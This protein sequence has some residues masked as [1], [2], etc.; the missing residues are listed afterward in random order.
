VK[1]ITILLACVLGVIALCVGN[2]PA[3]PLST[4]FTYQGSIDKSG[5][6]GS[7]T[8]TFTFKLFDA[9]NNGAQIG[10]TLSPAVTLL[11]NGQFSVPLDF[12][13]GLFDGN[14]RWLEITVQCPGDPAPVALAPRQ[15]LTAAP[16]ALYA[17]N[18]A[19]GGG[20]GFVLPYVGPVTSAAQDAFRIQNNA[21]TGAFSAIHG[22]SASATSG[23]TGVVFGEATATS[24]L[25]LGVNGLAT[26]SPQGTGVVGKGGATGGYFES[27]APNASSGF[28]GLFGV[29]ANAYGVRGTSTT[30]YGVY[31]SG[32]DGVHGTGTNAGVSGDGTGYGVLASSN[33]GY[34]VYATYGNFFS[35]P[36][37][38]NAGVYG[39][40]ASTN[41]S[42]AGVRGEGTQAS[43]VEGISSS[44]AGVYGHSTSS[45]GVSGASPSYFGVLGV[46]GSESGV[47][48][49]SGSASGVYGQ[50]SSPTG[51]GVFGTNSAG[52][53]IWGQSS[54]NARSG[55]VGVS[56]SA[57]GIGGFFANSAG[58]VALYAN[59]L[60]QVK[61]L[62]ILGADLAESFPVKERAIEPGTV[63]MIDGGETGVLRV[64]DDAYSHRVAGVVSGAN[65]LDA[66]VVLK[67]K[68]FDEPGHVSV[69]MSG[70]VW[71]KCDAG[72]QP[73]RPGD[74]LT[75]SER[76][77]HAMRATD[78]ERAYGAIL[79]KAMT[80]LETGTGLVLVLVNLQ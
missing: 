66:A 26:A 33:S 3:A 61:T 37:G 51:Y 52:D 28:A 29:A 4:A 20:G 68:A 34:G 27:F 11:E 69:A 36:N 7:G 47:K 62:Q 57:T 60:A 17:L 5:T 8:C 9:L 75:T 79:G 12:G 65:G 40:S 48:G 58:G 49:I 10:P 78:R 53:G 2:A 56:S 41:S 74:L 72:A 46:S 31:G 23:G 1:R 15:P 21:T 14:Q 18:A 63:V 35:P 71:V 70:R 44:G 16:Y 67:G 32:A 50:S 64:C 73:I 22:V 54:A 80:S 25:T 13:P 19:G 59:G 45:I 6:P 42:S 38:T 77:G 43:G 39:N 24:G 76:A 55:V 30:S